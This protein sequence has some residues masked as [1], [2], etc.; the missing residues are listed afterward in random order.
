MYIRPEPPPQKIQPQ[1]DA[2]FKRK[3][4]QQ[5]RHL[6]STIADETSRKFIKKTQGAHREDDLVEIFDDA[7]RVMFDMETF[8]CPRKAGTVFPPYSLLT[9]FH[10]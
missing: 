4:S 1:L 7:F 2:I 6:I 3:I 9:P 5:R 10:I 8:T